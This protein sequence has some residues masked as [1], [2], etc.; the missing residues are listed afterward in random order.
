MDPARL[1]IPFWKKRIAR[2]FVGPAGKSQ[3][4][5]RAAMAVGLLLL[6]RSYVASRLKL[7]AVAKAM[8]SG[9]K[10]W[11]PSFLSL[12][13][14]DVA[15]LSAGTSPALMGLKAIG[16]AGGLGLMAT[17][18]AD[19]KKAR[20]LEQVL[21]ASGDL[22]W[23][24]QGLL[25]LSPSTRAAT[26]AVGLGI[27]GA[28]AQTAAGVQ[29]IR[30]GV[31]LRDRSI[32]TLGALDLGGGLLWLGWEVMKWEQPIF[33]GSY[34][35]LM[36]GREGYANKEAVMKFLGTVKDETARDLA[37]GREILASAKNLVVEAFSEEPGQA[38]P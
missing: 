30:H 17:S 23:G 35:L 11:L 4:S 22:A 7:S 12:G 21:D 20:T 16:V 32:A 1:L 26:A 15:S 19:L 10:V 36:V 34:V 27:V 33:V 24:A 9:N 2:A 18:L 37:V 3:G 8:P 5:K 6:E 28:A 29:R 31:A 13:A 14:A 38:T 25:T